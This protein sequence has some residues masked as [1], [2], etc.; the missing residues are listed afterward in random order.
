MGTPTGG[1]GTKTSPQLRHLRSLRRQ[2]RVSGGGGSKRT[3]VAN[4]ITMAEL[5]EV[6]LDV[7]E[8]WKLKNSYLPNHI[9]LKQ[10]ER[11]LMGTVKRNNL[12]DEAGSQL[13]APGS[14]DG[15]VRRMHIPLSKLLGM[16]TRLKPEWT[17]SD[18]N[19]VSR[20]L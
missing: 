9:S 19:R 6:G 11:K 20:E 14:T 1:V 12:A 2:L 16:G 17:A 15:D 5:L 10:K 3:R 4:T 7:A 8:Y 13:A 18:F